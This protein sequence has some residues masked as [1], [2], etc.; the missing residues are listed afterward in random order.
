MIDKWVKQTTANASKCDSLDEVVGSHERAALTLG[1]PQIGSFFMLA[2]GG[3][4]L[5]IF[6]HVTEIAWKKYRRDVG[7]TTRDDPT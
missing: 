6:G 4:A 5:S 2:M 3:L 7:A 1:L